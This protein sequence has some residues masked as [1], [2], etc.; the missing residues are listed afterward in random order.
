MSPLPDHTGEVR[1]IAV[2]RALYL[3][4]LLL[5]VPAW[6]ALRRRYPRATITLVGLPWAEAFVARMGHLVDRLAPFP[7]YPGIPELPY[8]PAR[9]AAFLDEQRAQGYDLAVQM[10]GDGAAS[11]GLTAA[12]GARVSVG[13]VRP[14]DRRLAASLPY[15]DGEHE[16][17]RW[18]RLAGAL[19]APVEDS[20]PE[21][22]ITAADEA[23]AAALLG[24][25]AAAPIIALHLGA[26]DPA[27]RWPARRFGALGAALR[28][29]CGARLVLTG[30]A[31]EAE[32]AARARAELGEPALDLVGRT[33]LGPFAA[34][35][36]RVDLLVSNDTG[37][38]HLAAA[39]GT[40]SVVVYGPSRPAQF[41][42]L[43]RERHRVVDALEHARRG[44]D[45]A[46]A[47]RRLPVECVLHACFAQLGLARAARGAAAQAV[48]QEV[49]CA[50]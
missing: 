25:P 36:G 5:S 6:R 21:F 50:G 17:S 28:E 29:R 27:R 13:Y 43:D 49:L 33:D 34:L 15:A 9:T 14:G 47:L 20:R 22:R 39:A 30:T 31:G 44:E 38:S 32:L 48:G 10:H 41:A 8:D 46:L 11:N 45:P 18:L 2:V 19:G 24:P 16:V 40:P 4:D 42:P 7:G 26:K 37:A 12:L 23:A 35:L 1:A 3:G